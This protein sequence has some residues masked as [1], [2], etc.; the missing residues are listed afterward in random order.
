MYINVEYGRQ[1]SPV[2]PSQN[3]QFFQIFFQ[4]QTCIFTCTK[5]DSFHIYCYQFEL[6]E[7]PLT[8]KPLG[9]M[10]IYLWICALKIKYH[11]VAVSGLR[12]YWWTFLFLPNVLLLQGASLYV[13]R[14]Q[15]SME[16][17]VHTRSGIGGLWPYKFWM[18]LAKGQGQ[19]GGGTIACAGGSHLIGS[20]WMGLV[21]GGHI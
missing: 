19:D 15:I 12:Q 4:S 20:S 5:L 11:S 6:P 18:D 16:I 10:N 1:M 8:S 17:R 2:I 7:A 9:A 14:C 13:S 3:S 21:P